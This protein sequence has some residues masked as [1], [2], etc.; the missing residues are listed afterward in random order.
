MKDWKE[1]SQFL[2]V[3]VQDNEISLK[4][5]AQ[6]NYCFDPMWFQHYKETNVEHCSKHGGSI[7]LHFLTICK[8]RNVKCVTDAVLL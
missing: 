5:C 3:L 8:V 4:V 6:K 7:K 2:D 1:K